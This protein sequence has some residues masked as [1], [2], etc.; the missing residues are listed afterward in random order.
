MQTPKAAG[1]PTPCS[2]VFPAKTRARRAERSA[3]GGVRP[4]VGHMS[5][6]DG[7]LGGA[8]CGCPE[9]PPERVRFAARPRSEP[10]AREKELLQLVGV[11]GSLVAVLLEAAEDE[12]LELGQHRAAEFFA[13]ALGRRVQVVPA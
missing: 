4:L 3:R 6:A 10:L 1:V 13:R 12:R 5:G 11:F 9:A 7:R 2:G 8:G